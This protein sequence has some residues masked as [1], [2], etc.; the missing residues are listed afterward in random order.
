MRKLKTIFLATAALVSLAAPAFAA[1]GPQEV[2]KADLRLPH[3][4]GF[5]GGSCRNIS[6]PDIQPVQP[7]PDDEPAVEAARQHLLKRWLSATPPGD[8]MITVPTGT[9]AVP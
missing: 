2:G 6:S 7:L 4:C 5:V 8:T 9:P 3:V 1:D